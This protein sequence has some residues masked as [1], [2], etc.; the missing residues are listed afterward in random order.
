MISYGT[1]IVALL[2]SIATPA[3][4]QMNIEITGVGQSLYPIAVMRFKDE[5]KLPISITDII[6][7]DLARSG[8]FKN[9][10][11]GSAVESDRGQ[12]VAP[13]H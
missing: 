7:Q 11:N 9:T 6:R 1:V 12:H 13:M 8:Y 4:A 3:Y 5:N 2:I 10:E